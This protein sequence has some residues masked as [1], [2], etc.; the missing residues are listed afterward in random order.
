MAGVRVGM[1][2]ADAEIIEL[3]NRVKP[4]YNI[5]RPAQ[6]AIIRAMSDVGFVQTTI[7]RTALER[8]RLANELAELPSVIQVFPSDANFL[9]VRFEE[10]TKVYQH[11][12]SDG[13]IVRDRSSLSGCE[14]CLRIT[15]GTPAENERLLRALKQ[16]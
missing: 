8:N 1:A 6:E 3:F 11:L 2:F 7:E 4:P 9:L 5:S 16:L 12:V 13:I 14:R 10:H 15:V